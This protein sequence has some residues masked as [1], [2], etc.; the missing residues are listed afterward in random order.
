V[1]PVMASEIFSFSADAFGRVG[2]YA[3]IRL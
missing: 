1:V 2:S 3:Q